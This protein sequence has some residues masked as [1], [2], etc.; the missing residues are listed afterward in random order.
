M[1][2]V[3]YPWKGFAI[4]YLLPISIAIFILQGGFFLIPF[5]IIGFL[6]LGTIGVFF[7]EDE[8]ITRPI[9]Q[10][11]LYVNSPV[12]SE[13]HRQRLYAAREQA[14]KEETYAK[15]GCGCAWLLGI[16]FAIYLFGVFFN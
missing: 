5:L 14:E 13:L 7:H 9:P 1:R 12:S 8:R 4:F 15:F 3:K 6:I 10:E 2:R 16:P 11:D